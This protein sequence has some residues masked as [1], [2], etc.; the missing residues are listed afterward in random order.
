MPN[1]DPGII[2][3]HLN[4]YPSSK[5][6]RQKK[7]VF[8]P[9]RDNANK[10]EVQKLTATKFIREVYYPNWLANVVMVKRANRK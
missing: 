10:E 1:I 3:H 2:T 9:E 4:V 7:R 5:L 6:V 8:A